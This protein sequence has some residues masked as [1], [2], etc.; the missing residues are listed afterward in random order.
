MT[1]DHAC[2][3]AVKFFVA[4]G[5]P[6]AQAEFVPIF[7]SWIQTRAVADH[8]LIDV[9][10]YA[11]V[12]GGPGTMLIAHEGNFSMDTAGGRLGLLYNRKQPVAADVPFSQR[13][14]QVFGACLS[15]CA[16]LQAALPGRVR[17][18]SDDPILRINDRLLAPNNPD[19]FAKF[20]GQM[21]AFLE[22]LYGSPVRLEHRPDPHELF[23]VAIIAPNL[24]VARLLRP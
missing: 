13:L 8:Q 11:H 12:P 17:F 14:A 2:K 5:S 16:R 3:L 10:D 23:E 19:T 22:N 24:D 15:A 4:D 18:R 7:H 1:V 9:A 6:V 21:Q 20:R